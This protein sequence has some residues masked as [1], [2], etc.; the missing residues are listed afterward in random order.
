MTVQILG[1]NSTNNRVDGVIVNELTVVD[2]D[3]VR[4]T[5]VQITGLMVPLLM[6]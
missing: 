1:T 4:C 2:A 6:S 3:V 5:T